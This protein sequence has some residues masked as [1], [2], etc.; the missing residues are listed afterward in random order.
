VRQ[1]LDVYLAKSSV[2]TP[3]AVYIHGGGWQTSDKS[4]LSGQRMFLDRGISV[5]AIDYRYLPLENL[6]ASMPPVAVPL[7]DAARAIQFIRSKAAEW[8]LAKNVIGVW[9]ISAGACSALWLATHADMADPSSSD[10]ILRESTR[11]A[12][13]SAILA[14]TT[15]D[16]EQMRAWVG[17]KLTYGP[18]AFG[19]TARAGGFEAFLAARK[20][21]L[22]WI[23]A[24]S[25]AALLNRTSAPIFLDYRDFSLT[26]CEPI[27]AYYTHSPQFGIGFLKLASQV[28]AE[29][30]L[31][32]EGHEAERFGDW[33]QFVI[34]KTAKLSSLST[35]PG[36]V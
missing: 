27:D 4:N 12:Y 19:I 34:A 36:S 9:G 16:P 18:R 21:L 25:P 5:I 28:G 10:P 17:P 3:V 33:Q 2:P 20:R 11:P 26:P 24:Y 22:P 29:C 15:L 23:G 30:Y 32:Y 1:K 7:M 35:L 8:G 14:Q 31:R 6:S 13:A